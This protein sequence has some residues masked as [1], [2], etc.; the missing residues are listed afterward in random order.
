MK[1]S[2]RA[3]WLLLLSILAGL[4]CGCG[5]AFTEGGQNVLAAVSMEEVPI[6]NYTVPQLKP[7]IL[8]DQ[9][10]YC[11]EGKKEA[12]V[13][14]R[15]LP[16]GFRL[17]DAA[18]GEVVY[19]GSL[20][21]ISYNDEAGVYTGLAV[22]SDF[23]EE[24]RYYLEC[25]KIGRS[26]SF[27]IQA[28]AY[29]RLFLE[30]Y[31]ELIAACREQAASVSNVT[32]LLTVYEWYPAIFPDE[33]GNEIPDV[34]EEAAEW[35]ARR[36]QTGEHVKDSI[37]YV[38][39]L[40]KFSYLY[41]KFDIDYATECLQHASAIFTQEESIGQDADHF[42]ALTELYRAAGLS[43]YRNQI[44]DYTTFFQKN[45]SFLEEQ[46]YLYGAMTYMSTRQT[47]DITLCNVF[48]D[49]LM[50]RGEELSE[51]YGEM[52]DPFTARNNGADD[53][54][55]SVR[56]LS[57][58]NYILN[59]YEYTGIMEEFLH[60]LLGKNEGAVCF[61]PQEGEKSGYLFLLGQLAAT[62]DRR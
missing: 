18:T 25:D 50:G 21:K 12:A 17:M 19:S 39:A 43:A 8:V 10:A 11:S 42:Y 49:S 22:F 37:L 61:Y 9:L 41:Q 26:L 51:R 52:I 14:C 16:E 53:L 57:C 4:S 36:E 15:E 54:L 31:Q 5:A 28:N 44:A 29:E 40:A 48:M 60:Y 20:E 13:K 3:A 47:V 27:A 1:R 35:I 30:V 38:A 32:V 58:C 55:K 23:T 45:T 24:G 59:N 2:R 62:A 7:N 34:L 56:E 33:D 46:S 6:I